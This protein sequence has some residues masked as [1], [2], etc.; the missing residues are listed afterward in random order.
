V[1]FRTVQATEPQREVWL[2][3]RLGTE[4][5]LA[6]N[7]S[8]SISLRGEL[9]VAALRRA[10][11]EL[12]RRHDALRSTFTAD[13]LHLRVPEQA[14]ELDI[15]MHDLSG[16]PADEREA[17]QEA[18]RERHVM[19]PFDLEKGP[20]FRADLVRMAADCHVLILTGHHIVLDG[21]SYWVIVKDL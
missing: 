16:R 5:S 17:Q 8:V 1:G 21:W 3:D 20:L 6:Y 18:I 7:E 12:P 15:P 9:D 10:L 11:R 4:A 13:G 19:Q 14:P 2:A